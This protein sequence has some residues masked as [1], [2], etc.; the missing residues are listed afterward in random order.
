[1]FVA[2]VQTGSDKGAKRPRC[3]VVLHKALCQLLHELQPWEAKLQQ[4][5]KKMRNKLKSELTEWKKR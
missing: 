2:L 5:T 3:E 4:A 1:M